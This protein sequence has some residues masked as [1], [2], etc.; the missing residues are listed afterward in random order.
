MSFCWATINVK[1]MKESL[2][3]YQ[4]VIGLKMNR[5]FQ[6][7]PE[8]E[9]AFLGSGE[10]QIE[11]VCHKKQ[12]NTNFSNDISLGFTVESLDK[13]MEMLKQK[14]I[15]IIEGPFQPNPAIRFL[16]IHDT[17][18]LKIQFVENIAE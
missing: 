2:K 15:D 16:F 7:H 1:S 4:E 10:T 14:N 8:M 17:N 11:L 18:G 5:Q 6:P 13:T 12:I 9:L 3:F